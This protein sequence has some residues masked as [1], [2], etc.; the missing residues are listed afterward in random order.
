VTSEVQVPGARTGGFE[1]PTRGLG[2]RSR[3]PSSGPVRSGRWIRLGTSTFP[4]PESAG[5]APNQ[6]ESEALRRR[7]REAATPVTMRVTGVATSPAI[8][9]Y[10]EGV[11]GSSP[12]PP[13]Q[14]SSGNSVFVFSILIPGR[15]RST[16]CWSGAGSHDPLSLSFYRDRAAR[17]AR[18]ASR[19]AARPASR[20]GAG[21]KHSLQRTTRTPRP[22]SLPP[23]NVTL[24]SARRSSASPAR[25][26]ASE[27]SGHLERPS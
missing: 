27:G 23:S 16:K 24:R 13:I 9:L 8:P 12:S 10:T 7:H 17:G 26:S 5:I 21:D 4:V 15:L 6:T 19:R 1:P 22:T 3:R 18:R 20:R 14:K 2:V 11:G 25:S